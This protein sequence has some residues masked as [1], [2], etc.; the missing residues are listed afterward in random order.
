MSIKD[1][2][3]T[4]QDYIES[5][6]FKASLYTPGN[7]FVGLLDLINPSLSLKKDGFDLLNFSLSARIFDPTDPSSVIFQKNPFVDYA[8]DGYYIIFEF[9]DLTGSTPQQRRFIIKERNS[10]L[11]DEQATY[12][13][14]AISAEYELKKLPII[15]WPGVEVKEYKD[16]SREISSV[17]QVNDVAEPKLL[18]DAT[19]SYTPISLRH[20]PKDGEIL[21]SRVHKTYGIEIPLVKTEA[22]S[23]A[24]EQ[25]SENEY[26]YDSVNNEIITWIP[27]HISLPVDD[28]GNV[29]FNDPVDSYQYYIYYQT[30]DTINEN[31]DIIEGQFEK[32]Y[33][34]NT[35]GLT[36]NQIIDD[37]FQNLTSQDSNLRYFLQ[38]TYDSNN[39][40]SSDEIR[41][42][43][44]FSNTTVYD[45]MKSLEEN[46]QVYIDF[47]T[48]NR[49][50]TIREENFGTN[51][52][53]RFEYGKYL[54]GV[55]KQY[56]TDEVI[57]YIQG[58]DGAGVGFAD[59]SWSGDNY[60][61]NY[62]YYLDG[63][64]W[65]PNE[66]L[67][68]KLIGTSR[69]IS[70]ELAEVLAKIKYYQGRY[71][72][73]VWGAE[74][75]R[76]G[77]ANIIFRLQQELVDLQLEIEE[78]DAL[79]TYRQALIDTYDN[80]T[81]EQKA[82]LD[83]G[84]QK[85]PVNLLTN[86]GVGQ[87]Y[88]SDISE[89]LTPSQS[90]LTWQD[91]FIDGDYQNNF[92]FK[93]FYL[94][95]S[96]IEPSFTL[97]RNSNVSKSDFMS[98]ITVTF[99]DE[100]G[101][102]VLT[103]YLTIF[104]MNKEIF[105][106][107]EITA[108]K[109]DLDI[110]M[111]NFDPDIWG[112]S[113]IV[114]LRLSVYED[115]WSLGSVYTPTN[116]RDYQKIMELQFQ[117]NKT[118]LENRYNR[119][120][121]GLNVTYSGGAFDEND[122]YKPD[123][124]NTSQLGIAQLEMRL[125]TIRQWT[126][127]DHDD[128]EPNVLNELKSIRRGAVY[129]NKDIR[130]SKNL[131]L[132]AK[133]EL[134]EKIYPMITIGISSVSILQT[135]EAYED[136]EKV[137]IGEKVDIYVDELDINIE[138]EI[139]EIK[140]D[141]QNYSTS[142]VISTVKDYD[143]SFGRLFANTFLLGQKTS[144]NDLLPN[145]PLIERTE[146]FERVYDATF[147]EATAGQINVSVNQKEPYQDI[148]TKRII[149]SPGTKIEASTPKSSQEIE[150][151][152]EEWKS[153]YI[154]LEQNTLTDIKPPYYAQAKNKGKAKVSNGGLI[155]KDDSDIVRIKIN[156]T[157]GF[158]GYKT[159]SGVTTESFKIDLNG[160]ATFAGKLEAATGVFSGDIAAENLYVT[161]NGQLGTSLFFE[162]NTAY[163]IDDIRTINLFRFGG[164][165][166]L[167]SVVDF[168][169]ERTPISLQITRT[170]D[171]INYKLE[172]STDEN[173]WTELLGFRP[174]SEVVI[175]DFEL[176][177]FQFLRVTALVGA[178]ESFGS[179]FT[180]RLRVKDGHTDQNLEIYNITK[181]QTTNAYD[182]TDDKD[183]I[184]K[185]YADATYLNTSTRTGNKT[186]LQTTEPTGDLIEGDIWFHEGGE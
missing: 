74:G 15:N 142:I 26:Y 87:S 31:T 163:D 111:N 90:T 126:A 17:E 18:E 48:V 165:E 61:E 34:Y 99:K 117:L 167:S 182:V 21:V 22:P 38:W 120:N 2:N 134:E 133:K 110:V 102:I 174:A 49:I 23:D 112:R 156:A 151:S 144:Q 136:W 39:S 85:I 70:S 96:P 115:G 14:T 155:I 131:F 129:Q 6:K 154:N 47:D 164:N 93:S 46:Y 106:G 80:E 92:T 185:G 183:L 65:D 143:R 44:N 162:D 43:L 41:S 175:T 81:T 157:D 53:L 63:A 169:Q 83:K 86:I 138:A 32:A 45:I 67:S 140:I 159:E 79:I 9:G 1:I 130:D 64:Y 51:N 145:I 25:M 168:D 58:Q 186:F 19:G 124:E 116:Y 148:V 158:V 98:R 68:G 114:I 33:F 13:Y 95:G 118:F 3:E 132:A 37:L 107:E 12:S 128:L 52:G 171:P 77:I 172:V 135:Y 10:E 5:E 104:D 176:K 72:E 42:G 180:F 24:L 54:I 30:T 4:Y 166:R 125:Q 50:I 94:S 100:N 76:E 16:I 170:G 57:N 177:K 20:T 59:I 184:T 119:I 78:L 153:K 178:A 56:N 89:V 146:E 28:V 84:V 161:N 127:I 97:E 108:K 27:A 173:S 139:K 88:Y 152:T 179:S 181:A 149:K 122:V 36:I 121:Y 66:G 105:L 71:E 103:K 7:V 109:Y 29:N 69:W 75:G 137:R 62:D 82:T 141:F 8:L 113:I 35:D 73:E 123:V 147:G 40:I 101:D 11:K 150:V 160:N 55:N 91:K 60:I